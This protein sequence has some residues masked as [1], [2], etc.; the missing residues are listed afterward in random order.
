LRRPTLAWGLAAKGAAGA[1]KTTT[2]SRKKKA[3]YNNQKRKMVQ[4]GLCA[5]TY[6]AWFLV[7]GYQQRLQV[8]GLEVQAVAVSVKERLRQYQTLG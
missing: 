7:H 2:N 1:L 4:R 5:V 6:A 8:H 3:V